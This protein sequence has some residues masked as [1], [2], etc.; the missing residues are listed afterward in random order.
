MCSSMLNANAVKNDND[1]AFA[2]LSPVSVDAIHEIVDVPCQRRVQFT[3]ATTYVFPI[4]L[5]ASALPKETGAPV[6][7]AWTHSSMYTTDLSKSR[8]CKRGRVCKFKHAE[9]IALLKTAGVDLREIA[10]YC[11]EAI[12]IRQSRAEAII[13]YR[14]EKLRAREAEIES[15]DEEPTPKRRRMYYPTATMA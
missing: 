5:G 1:Y 6:G 11:G 9:R 12:D 2:P 8:A 15:F 3:T 7:M 4:A 10:S 14:R 13:E